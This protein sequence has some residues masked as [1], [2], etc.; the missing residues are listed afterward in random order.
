MD[1]S[2]WPL[3]I[4]REKL[5]GK[6]D[7]WLGDTDIYNS[8]ILHKLQTNKTTSHSLQPHCCTYV[9]RIV[10]I[11]DEVSKLLSLI[12]FRNAADSAESCVQCQGGASEE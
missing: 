7:K 3:K 11:D 5:A 8:R 9:S 6:A 12:E 4:T 1:L 10:L 2:F